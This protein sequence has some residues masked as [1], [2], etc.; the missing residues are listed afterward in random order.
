MLLFY[1]NSLLKDK[2]NELHVV[3]NIKVSAV[4]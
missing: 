2:L 3:R 1:N 4:F